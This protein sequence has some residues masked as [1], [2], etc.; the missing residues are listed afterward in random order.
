M[1]VEQQIK[2]TLKR[3]LKNKV[4]L[5]I[6]VEHRYTTLCMIDYHG[7]FNLQ[8][9][10]GLKSLLL[11]LFLLVPETLLP[12]KRHYSAPRK[13]DGWKQCMRRWSHSRRIGHGILFHY[14]RGK[15]QLVASGSTRRSQQYQKKK[16]KS[17]RLA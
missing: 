10:L 5:K 13:I 4:E 8:C 7:K 3:K 9:G 6:K 16:G 2:M 14:Q 15:E 1:K 17:S 11:M 12:F